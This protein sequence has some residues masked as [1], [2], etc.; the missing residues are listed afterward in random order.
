MTQ[1]AKVDNCVVRVYVTYMLQGQGEQSWKRERER[2][3]SCN[4]ML[5]VIIRIVL[6][7]ANNH[8]R[9]NYGKNMY[10]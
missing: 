1:V 7:V 4:V 6:L 5:F 10:R 9:K 8:Q 3:E 2:R